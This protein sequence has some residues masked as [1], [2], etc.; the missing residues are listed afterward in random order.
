MK[1]H[2][3]TMNDELRPEYDLSQLLKGG[4]RGK[5]AECYYAGTNLVPPGPRC[6]QG[7]SHKKSR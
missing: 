7:L 3:N 6:P 4:V 2:K 5:K 1:T